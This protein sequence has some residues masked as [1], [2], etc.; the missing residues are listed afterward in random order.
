[1]F[2]CRRTGMVMVAGLVTAIGP[3][4]QGLAQDKPGDAASTAGKDAVYAG[5]PLRGIGPALMSGRVSDIAVDPVKRSTWYVVAASGGV[6]KTTNS[7]T[8]WTPIFDGY[9][10]YSIGCVAVDPSNHLVVWVGT[11]EN[12][13]QRSVGY[14]DGLYK[15]IDGGASFTKVGLESSEHIAKVLIDP[16][17][18][19]VVYV[20]AQGPLWKAGR[21]PR[22]VQ[23]DRRRQDLE[24]RALDQREHGRDRRRVRSAQ[25]RR[26]LCRRLP[27]PAARLDADRRRARV[28]PLPID[29]RRARPGGRSTRDFPTATRGA[30]A[31]RSRRSIPTSST[32]R[33]RPPGARAAFSAPTTAAKAGP[34]GR[35]TSP[36]ARSTT[37][38]S[39]P[40]PMCSTASMRW[41]RS[42][43]SPRTA[44]RR[45][46]RWAS[47]GSTS[48][49]T[50]SGSTRRIPIT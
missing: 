6:W 49:I 20:A 48:I 17:N 34:S 35:A 2:N 41:T 23:D 3:A 42:C 4:A 36:A 43:R 24:G 26:A 46:T 50:R 21:R 38:G 40:T 29:R 15:S 19:N 13:S 32:P 18:S 9:G 30:S 33:S 16:R 5:L 1:M 10:S 12:N 31:W 22:A 28:G 8:T 11:G 27:A 47:A 39:S 45:F 44:A 37:R 25:S 7:G 14:G